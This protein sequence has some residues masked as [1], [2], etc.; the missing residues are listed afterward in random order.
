MIKYMICS[1][2]FHFTIPHA[3]LEVG[4]TQRFEQL[5]WLKKMTFI[6]KV[7]LKNVQV[8][9]HV[10]VHVHVHAGNQEVEMNECLH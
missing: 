7:K 3:T 8:H 10:P 2:T 6:G 5:F 1:H 4:S 9:V